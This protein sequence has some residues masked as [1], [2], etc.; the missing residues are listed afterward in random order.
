MVL[1]AMN[2]LQF[3]LPSMG[4]AVASIN[5][6][7]ATALAL[8]SG[9]LTLLNMTSAELIRCIASCGNGSP[10]CAVFPTWSIGN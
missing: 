8:L 4:Y 7:S 6:K 1:Y 3:C 10:K 2:H 5:M 9:W